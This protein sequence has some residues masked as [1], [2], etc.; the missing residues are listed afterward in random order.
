MKTYLN[1][2]YE[3][4]N[5]PRKPSNEEKIADY[6]VNF[7]KER[8]LKYF[9]DAINNVIIFKEASI[10][11]EDKELIILQSH[12]D[13]I[14]EK[15][16]G[17][18]HDF[19]TQGLDLYVDGDFLKARGT[20]LGA[21]DGIGVA[22]MLAI[23][24]SDIETPPLECLFT[25]QEETTMNGARM[26]DSSKLMSNKIISFD[27]F[28]EDFMWVSSSNSKEWI[29]KT[30]KEYENTPKDYVTYKLELKNFKGGHSG[31]DIGDE[32]RVNPIK[33][34][35]E[36]LK[37]YDVCINEVKGGSRVNIIPREFAI[38]FSTKEKLDTL[39]SKIEGYKIYGDITLSEIQFCEKCFSQSLTK[40][41]LDFVF[42][43]KNGVCAYD[44]EN[45]IILSANMGAIEEDECEILFKYSLRANDKN[46]GEKLKTE[47][48]TLMSKNGIEIKEYDE[49]AGYFPDM[50]NS[51]ISKCS[52]VYKECFGKDIKKIKT[53][54]CLECGFFAEKIK[55][56]EYVAIAPNIYDAHSPNEKLSISSA[57]RMWGYVVKLLSS[58]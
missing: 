5:V 14:C 52:S 58:I 31:L 37:G 36:L 55:N 3:I 7:A 41:L 17:V 10:G 2:F 23:L 38:T 33:L 47:I 42:Y 44:D 45:N 13:M 22:Y 35:A 53:Q 12:M 43:F 46:L 6:L 51:L 8:N 39:I 1:Y 9:R 21:D 19:L 50:N 32:T 27:C 48:D 11:N 20:T 30:K 24:D 26:I 29:S 34:A 15:E 40:R 49:M 18:A 56:L 57:D 4:S 54:A 28:S 25:V 16:L